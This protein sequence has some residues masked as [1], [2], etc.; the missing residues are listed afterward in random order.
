M[1]DFDFV[2]VV[3]GAGLVLCANAAT[4]SVLLAARASARARAWTY[5]NGGSLDCKTGT[6]RT[7]SQRCY[8]TALFH[9]R[10]IKYAGIAAGIRRGDVI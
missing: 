7:S 8:Q 9:R 4:L 1:V 5:M 3:A 6:C 10:P 2:I